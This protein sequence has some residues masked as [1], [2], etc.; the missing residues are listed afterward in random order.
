MASVWYKETASCTP[1]ETT[2]KALWKEDGRGVRAVFFGLLD[3]P[4]EFDN[5]F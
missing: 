1:R 2:D 3:C 5:K 4:A